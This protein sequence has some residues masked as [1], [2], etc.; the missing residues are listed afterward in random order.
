VTNNSTDTGAQVALRLSEMGLEE[1]RLHVLTATELVGLHL[2]ERHGSMAMKV[3]GSESL[4][5][6]L[7]RHGHRLIPLSSGR[8]ADAVVIGRDLTFDYAKLQMIVEELDR[9]TP[10]IAT[11]PDL[12]HPGSRGEKVLETGALYKPAEE[13]TGRAVEYFG[14]PAPH[15]FH[16]AMRQCGVTRPEACVMVGDNL[17][18]DIAG[19]RASGIRTLWLCGAANV[20]S[21]AALSGTGTVRASV[22]ADAG[23]LADYAVA[24]LNVIARCC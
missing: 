10:V 5:Q 19:G 2:L 8:R 22:T 14:K 1:D 3:V 12:Y 20:A 23:G 18:T 15:M 17:L 11:N 24:D 4:Q 6:S 7:V 16:M 13:I 9:G 21:A